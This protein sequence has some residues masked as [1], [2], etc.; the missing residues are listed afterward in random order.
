MK[1]LLLNGSPNEHGCT[2]RALTEVAN[3]LKENGVDS[4]IL[5]IGKGA[6]HGCIGCGG[7]SKLGHCVFGED[8]VNEAV[9]R[10]KEADGLIVGSPVYYASPNGSILSFLDRMF[11]S[12]GRYLTHKPAAAVASA[13]RA[14]TTATLDA[15]NKYFLINQMPIV[16]SNYWNMVH[17]KAPEDVEKDL[18]GLQIMRILGQNMAWMLKCIEAG[19]EKGI[20][21]PEGETKI[22]TNFIR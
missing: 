2:F 18:E 10:A 13:R 7:C 14:G 15:L 22:M 4:E 12:G 8:G 5:Q 16:S 6:I 9:E 17:G 20:V 11:Y 19:R 21:C 1:V 3:S